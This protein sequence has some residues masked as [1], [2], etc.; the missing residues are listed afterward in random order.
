MPIA[1]DQ[2]SELKHA[3]QVLG[4]PLDA[5]VLAIKQSYRAL[6]KRWHPDLYSS[7][8]PSHAEAVQMSKLINEAYS[9]I[10][11]A[12]LRYFVEAFLP[13]KAKN[14]Q[15]SSPSSREPAIADVEE[16]PNVERIEFWVRLVLG[17]VVG[18][19]LSWDLVLNFYEQPVIL[20]LGAL[21][22]ILGLGFASV[23]YGD[24]LWH[25]IFRRWW[26]WP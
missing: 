22:L 9:A 2:L 1:E 24:K 23:R 7:G 18:A 19:L 5:S 4:V 12:P 26:L 10:E 21:I 15:T 11:N 17:A 14:K 3:Y 20:V 8:T 16:L 13:A 6:L 25:A